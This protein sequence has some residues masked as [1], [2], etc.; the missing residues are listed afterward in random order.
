MKDGEK[1]GKLLVKFWENDAIKRTGEVRYEV[2]DGK[3]KV[4]VPYKYISGYGEDGT[5]IWTETEHIEEKTFEEWFG[6]STEATLSVKY[7][8]QISDKTTVSFEARDEKVLIAPDGKVEV[9]EN[10][11]KPINE[12]DKAAQMGKKPDRYNW[13]D[14]RPCLAHVDVKTDALTGQIETGR[15]ENGKPVYEEI[16]GAVSKVQVYLDGKEVPMYTGTVIDDNRQDREFLTASRGQKDTSGMKSDEM[17]GCTSN[18]LHY[19][20]KDE[21]GN[22][23]NVLI[24]IKALITYTL[25]DGKEREFQYT[26]NVYPEPSK[27]YNDKFEYVAEG[28]E[29]TI[30]RC[31]WWSN[32]GG[33]DY[34][35]KADVI[36]ELIK[37]D[38]QQI[39]TNEVKLTVS[40]DK[41]TL[42]PKPT[43]EP[44]PAPS[45]SPAPSENP[46]TT[47]EA[48]PAPSGDPG[49]TPEVTPAPSG[50]PGT[51]P[52]ATPVPGTTPTPEAASTPEITP[53]PENTPEPE[54]EP[55]RTPEPGT[56]PGGDEPGG[57][58]ATVLGARRLQIN[59]RD[60]AVLGAKRGLESAVLGKRRSPATG[61][62]AEM[63]LWILV[64]SIA[65]GGAFSSGIMLG[66]GKKKSN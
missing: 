19:F 23:K 38:M 27:I 64:L 13:H 2:K 32:D 37:Q 53:E 5:P 29:S 6:S 36:K 4:V 25:P 11:G 59:A 8:Y 9:I 46:G 3:I 65:I 35:I 49:T 41:V 63:F 52:E 34:T 56:V 50:D 58:V 10:G 66:R 22:Y 60:A 20:E 40:Q 51:T 15:D 55:E 1:E 12:E 48:T 57:P 45:E 18:P 30:N 7:A 26:V 54:S 21:A 16:N 43:D 39:N 17:E 62:N 61:D 14:G 28:E 33:F 47:P 24:T 42:E 31:K 44:T